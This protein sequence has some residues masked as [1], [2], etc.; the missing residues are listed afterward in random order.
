[1]QFL[2]SEAAP[3]FTETK[4]LFKSVEGKLFHLS[5]ECDLNHLDMISISDSVQRYVPID[6][7]DVKSLAEVLCRI[8]RFHENATE[9]REELNNIQD[10]MYAELTSG[11]SILE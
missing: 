1:M 3:E 7:E 5:V 9:L 6:I 2:I 4:G 8:V 10:F 11:D